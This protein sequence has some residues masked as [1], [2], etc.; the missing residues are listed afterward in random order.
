MLINISN[1][2]TIFQDVYNCQ[3]VVRMNIY[4]IIFFVLGINLNEVMEATRPGPKDSAILIREPG[5]RFM[6]A[7]IDNYLLATR[8]FGKNICSRTTH[9]VAKFCCLVGGRQYGNYLITCFLFIKLLYI[10]NAI[11][12]LFLLDRFLAIDYYF[13]GIHMAVKLF[14]GEEDWSATDRFPRVTL[15]N[16]NIRHM[17]RLHSYVVQCVL[18]INLFNEKIFLFIWYW[19][20][21]IAIITFYTAVKWAVTSMF[22]PWQIT[23]V[24]QKLRVSETTLHRDSVILEKFTRSYLRR[25]GIFIL[26]LIEMNVGQSIATDVIHA[27][28]TNYNPRKRLLAEKPQWKEDRTLKHDKQTSALGQF[29]SI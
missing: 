13:Y 9:I 24:W 20:V 23:Y 25:D 15:C 28:W 1:M 29:D 2:N 7:R 14:K 17:G 6:A 11:G 5:V 22:W 21:Y 18:A 19:F 3:M 27:L 10:G 4:K 16:F 12:Q 8:D 26:R